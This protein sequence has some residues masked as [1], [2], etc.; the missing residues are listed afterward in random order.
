MTSA[1]GRLDALEGVRAF[2]ALTVLTFHLSFFTFAPN[3][4]WFGSAFLQ[5]NVGVW[6]FFVL[7][8]FLLYT[9]YVASRRSGTPVRLRPY[10]RRRLLRIYPAYWVALVFVPWLL[11]PSWRFRHWP[12][13]LSSALLVDTYTHVRAIA[14]PGLWQSWTLVV[15]VSFYL[16][17]PLYAAVLARLARGR[18]GP[19]VEWIGIVGLAVVG[20]AATAWGAFRG[21]PLWLQILPAYFTP[22]AVGMGAAV[23]RQFSVPL[24]RPGRSYA[25]G[26]AAWVAVVVV[27]IAAP[28]SAGYDLVRFL[29]FTIAAGGLVVPL[30]NPNVL[31]R[32]ASVTRSRPMVAL[33]RI[34]YSIYLWHF[35]WIVFVTSH[36][37]GPHSS[38][39]FA[40]TTAVAVPLTLLTSAISYR[41]VERPAMMLG[42]RTTPQDPKPVALRHP[43][44]MRPPHDPAPALGDS[45]TAR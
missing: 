4:G 27:N 42:R 2:A 5:L 37:F 33:G 26:V 8:G 36:W 3:A 21:G 30:T 41:L 25:A 11:A 20:I 43:P 16:F 17:L 28:R 1:P 29:G 35:G 15:E 7:S 39:T 32:V 6:I 34:S 10:L 45:P 38:F 12:I 14:T 24:P 23:A 44:V 22:F 40:K 18:S 31:G 19:R 9:P 13:A